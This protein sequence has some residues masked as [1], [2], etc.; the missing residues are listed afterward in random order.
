MK[1]SNSTIVYGSLISH[2][3][4]F[5]FTICLVRYINDIVNDPHCQQID[6]GKRTFV[7]LYAWFLLIVTGIAVAGL[8]FLILK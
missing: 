7:Y 8:L 2:L 5:I 6:K 3:I 4:V 1:K